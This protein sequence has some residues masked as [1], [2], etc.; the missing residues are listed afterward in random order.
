[1]RNTRD[2][3]LIVVFTVFFPLICVPA[4]FV[5]FYCVNWFLAL[6]VFGS[7]PLPF[8]L[9]AVAG[10]VVGVGF[11]AINLRRT[12]RTLLQLFSSSTNESTT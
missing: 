11:T 12:W 10:L 1:M 7:A 4:A 8:W 9:F 2:K 3:V 6:H 5:A